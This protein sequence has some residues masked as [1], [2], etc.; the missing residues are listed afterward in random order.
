[1]LNCIHIYDS[2]CSKC[3]Q[4]AMYKWITC[5]SYKLDCPDYVCTICGEI[6]PIKKETQRVSR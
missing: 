5:P 2:E 4:D 6:T 3:G 1:M